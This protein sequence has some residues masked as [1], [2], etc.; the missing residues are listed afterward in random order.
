MVG[1]PVPHRTDSND[2]ER[3]F[4][5]NEDLGVDSSLWLRAARQLMCDGKP[6]GQ[7][8][9]LAFKSADGK[10]L[11]FGA[12]AHTN[13]DRII[14]WPVLPRNAEMVARKGTLDVLDHL[15]LELPSG[16]MHATAYGVTGEPVHCSAADLGHPQAWRLHRLEGH[17]LALWFT[18]LV[19]W[20]V[21][22]EQDFAVQ[23]RVK[24]PRGDEQR[25]TQEFV[26]FAGQI[27]VMD[28]PLPETVLEPNYVYC[29]A[30]F[31]PDAC[32]EVT[33]PPGAILTSGLGA[34]IDG[35]RADAIVDVRPLKLR[36]EHTQFVFAAACPPGTL[37][38]D[39][40]VGLPRGCGG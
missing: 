16:K 1:D 30:Y 7:L 13:R 27:K 29:L 25:R 24:M 12:L 40:F 4:R 10:S 39:V 11:P 18:L 6:L 37:T 28:V 33:L 38:D 36:Y 9:V 3:L 5:E 17:D 22:K 32:A 2:I 26:R 23:R 20:D 34:H 31:V 21:L 35:C 14:F 15:T 8:T 19:R